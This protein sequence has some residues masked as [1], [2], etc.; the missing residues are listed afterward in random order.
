LGAHGSH[1]ISSAGEA[2]QALRPLAGSAAS[3]V[4]ALG[5][6]GSGMLAI[7]VLAGSGSVGLSG[8]IGCRWGFSRRLRDAPV[9]YALVLFGTLTG[10]ALSAA[11]L[12]PIKLLVWVAIVNGIAAAPF[13]IVVMIVANNAALMGKHRN[14]RLANILGWTT[15]GLMAAAAVAFFLTG[16]ADGL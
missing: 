15:T 1:D 7:P 10:T 8:L 6:I 5:F 14:G 13:L 16:G 12:D 4:F 9:F 2:A 3:V 11:H